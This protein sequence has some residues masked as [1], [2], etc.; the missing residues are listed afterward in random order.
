MDLTSFHVFL[1]LLLLSSQLLAVSSCRY[2]SQMLHEIIP[3]IVNQIYLQI[4]C[5]IFK[6]WTVVS[7]GK[8]S[9]DL[10][11]QVMFEGFSGPRV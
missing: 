7:Y 1:K 2:C 10:W 5:T 8:L 11:I 6:L 4:I 9:D 3:L